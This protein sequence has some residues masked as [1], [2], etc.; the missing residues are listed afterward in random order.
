[1]AKE[2]RLNQLQ[3]KFA[4]TITKKGN[5]YC[6]VFPNSSREFGYKC[7]LKELA[8]KLNISIAYT[9][10]DNNTYDTKI[11]SDN[12]LTGWDNDKKFSSLL[13]QDS[14]LKLVPQKIIEL[15]NLSYANKLKEDEIFK[16]ET[17]YTLYAEVDIKKELIIFV[18]TDRPNGWAGEKQENYKFKTNKRYYKIS[19]FSNNY[20]AKTNFDLQEHIKRKIEE[21]SK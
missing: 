17:L 3:E 8:E 18:I 7:N 9:L 12:K 10:E 14:F 16:T 21:L 19:C 2:L 11:K 4:G 15:F 13:S 1:M 5:K 6:V 20:F